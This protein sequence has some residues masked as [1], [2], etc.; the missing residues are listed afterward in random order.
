M[1]S[2]GVPDVDSELERELAEIV[3]GKV[4]NTIVVSENRCPVCGKY[5]SSQLGK[6]TNIRI[7]DNCK[8]SF[9]YRPKKSLG[10]F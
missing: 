3:L 10:R 5:E 8:T 6:C 4:G 9:M 2:W 7:C 1:V